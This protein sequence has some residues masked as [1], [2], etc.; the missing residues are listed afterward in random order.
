MKKIVLTSFI[1]IF[2]VNLLFAQ[3]SA[4]PDYVCAGSTEEYKIENHDA[5]STYTWS[6]ENGSGTIQAT[7]V[8]SVIK[9]K[10]KDTGGTDKIK[11]YE[12][13]QAGCK[14][15]TYT[16]DVVRLVAPTAKLSSDKVCYGEKLQ[17]EFTGTA[18]FSIEYTFNGST[19]KV[20]DINSTKYDLGG[21]SGDY[22][23]VKVSSSSCVGTIASGGISNATI[24]KPLKTL[25][26]IRTK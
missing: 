8:S 24:A 4:N 21:E 5:N 6:I 15:D 7:A 25:R 20:S 3:S 2:A 9:I 16:L 14:G 10:W 26:I 13:N 1:V 18:P 19:K 17:V 12:T 22:S 23:L 11:V